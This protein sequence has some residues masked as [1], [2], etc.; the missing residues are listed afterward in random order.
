VRS[1]AYYHF[2]G[3]DMRFALYPLICAA[4]AGILLVAA[5]LLRLR[6]SLRSLAIFVLLA[7]CCEAMRGCS[8]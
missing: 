3:G 6:Y 7:G 8:P 1:A 4:A 5:R 2:E